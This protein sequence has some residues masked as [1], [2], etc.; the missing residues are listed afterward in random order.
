MADVIKPFARKEILQ[1]SGFLKELKKHK[2]L[3]QVIEIK[4][5]DL[6]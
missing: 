4:E 6:E 3:D 1:L 5:K 2:A